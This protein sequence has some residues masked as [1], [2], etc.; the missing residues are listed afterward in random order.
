MLEL[1]S[2]WLRMYRVYLEESNVHI[3]SLVGSKWGEAG[4][5]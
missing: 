1:T 4:A 3:T 2:V 5:D